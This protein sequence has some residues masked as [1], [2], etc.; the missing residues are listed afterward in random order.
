ML[1]RTE[2]KIM[3]YIG[4]RLKTQYPVIVTTYMTDIHEEFDKIIK[5]F[6]LQKILVSSPDDFVPP[7]LEFNFRYL[8]KTK[9]YK[10]FL[11]NREKLRKNLLIPYPFIRSILNYSK[12]DFP[13]ILNDFGAYRKNSKGIEQWLLLTDFEKMVTKDL[14]DNAI[15]LKKDWYPKIVR[16]LKKHYRRHT[17]PMPLWPKI[18]VC[19]KGLINR[20]IGELKIRTFEHLFNVILDKK[21]TPYF[22]L[23]SI[24]SCGKIDLEPNFDDIHQTFQNILKTIE[25]I[26]TNL[27]V[28]EPQIDMQFNTSDDFLTIKIGDVYMKGI[29]DRLHD[30]LN[31]A[32]A[33]ILCY[34]DT[35]R[36][37][38]YGLYGDPTFNDIEDFLSERRTF[39]EYLEKIDLFHDFIGILR[40][41]VLNEFFNVATINQTKCIT[42]LRAIAQ[43][44]IQKITPNIVVAHQKDCEDICSIFKNIKSR[45]M[46]IP[47]T[48]EMLLANGEYMLYVK[49]KQMA[50]LQ[51]RIQ[52]SLRVCI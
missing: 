16:I 12:T 21:L 9:N 36:D 18:F 11:Q 44:Y 33:P 27:P 50:Q 3:S 25:L 49:T 45:A 46:E 32:Y 2:K 13:E 38:Y 28:L 24:C 26:G 31:K 1:N 8:G 10:T 35:F 37:K 20:Q 17:V 40:R 52:D 22:R 15:F 43:E 48:T 6:S 41:Q 42:G 14:S 30:Q 29:Y 39:E 7:K 5:A 47:T 23:Q 19:A 34:L 4:L 51:L